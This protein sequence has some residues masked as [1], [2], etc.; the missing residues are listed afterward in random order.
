MWIS[1]I[2]ESLL[3]RYG[4]EEKICDENDRVYKDVLI[5]RRDYTISKLDKI[6]IEELVKAKRDTIG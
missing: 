2:P 3:K 5:H 1:P 4:L 6:F